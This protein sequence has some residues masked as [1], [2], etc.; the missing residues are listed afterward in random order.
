MDKQK[1][2][3]HAVAGSG[4]TSLIIDELTLEK[5]IAIIT[6]TISNQ[7]VLKEKVIKKFGCIPDN[8]H[9][10]GFW[11]FIYSFCLVP[12]L[13]WKPNGIIY[14]EEIKRAN[15]FR[16]RKLAYG[17][18]GYIFENMISKFLF[19]ES[20]PYLERIDEFFDEIYIDE[21]QDFDSYDLDWLLSLAR[22]KIKVW[23][24]GDYYQRTYSTSKSGNKSST[25]MKDYSSYK[26]VFEKAGYHFNDTLLNNSRRCS[27]EIC[28]FI[29]EKIGIAIGSHKE[30]GNSTISLIQD[31]TEILSILADDSIKKL[32]FKEHY[33]YC[34][35]SINWGESKGQT[36][37]NI[38]VV[39]NPESFKL[40]SKNK[41]I[42]M[43]P[44]TKSKFYVACTRSLGNL[45][46]IE[47]KN[48]PKNVIV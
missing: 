33:K 20:I 15:K 12:C 39:L 21:M 38:C 34:C 19:D 23:L 10:F 43:K 18:K 17:V 27:P 47:Q 1:Q 13:H 48:I 45:Y 35:N 40:Y 37:E 30:N 7:S 8:I 28:S 16:N 5:D 32:F 25:V 41:L 4:K 42:E 44:T 2:V 14:D 29:S 24:V 36:Y 22:T 31:E 6:Y 3:V 9:I 11:Q 26:G 46:F